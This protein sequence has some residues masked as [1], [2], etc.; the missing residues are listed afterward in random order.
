MSTI[1]STRERELQASPHNLAGHAD[2]MPAEAG[3][4]ITFMSRPRVNFTT[5]LGAPEGG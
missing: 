2:P 4:I 1:L 5:E 3:C